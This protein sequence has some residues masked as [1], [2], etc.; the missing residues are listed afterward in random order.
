MPPILSVLRISSAC[1]VSDPVCLL[2]SR[3]TRQDL[4]YK[5]LRAVA[6]TAPCAVLPLDMWFSSQE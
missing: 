5:P 4:T 1:S 2:M 6:L 3:Q